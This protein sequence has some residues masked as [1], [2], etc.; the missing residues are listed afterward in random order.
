VDLVYL[1]G[2]VRRTPLETQRLA[3]KQVLVGQV[4][5]FLVKELLVFGVGL[6]LLRQ[7]SVL[8]S[9]LLLL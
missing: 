4:L 5:E 9:K 8:L 7:G 1:H 6:D 2:L 3:V